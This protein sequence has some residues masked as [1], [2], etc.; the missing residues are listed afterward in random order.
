M[1]PQSSLSLRLCSALT[2]RLRALVLSRRAVGRV[3]TSLIATEALLVVVHQLIRRPE[4]LGAGTVVDG[5]CRVWT[6]VSH[7]PKRR[8]AAVVE[9]AVGYIEMANELGEPP[10]DQSK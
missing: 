4:G 3:G 5:Q 8:I 9:A 6:C 7:A 10:S 2:L 1:A